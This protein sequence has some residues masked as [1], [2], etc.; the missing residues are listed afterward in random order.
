MDL[1][2]QKAKNEN[3]VFDKASRVL[4]VCVPDPKY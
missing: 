1:E 3:Y 4:A 2:N